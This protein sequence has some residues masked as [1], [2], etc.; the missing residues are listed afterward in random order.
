M[1]AQSP[2]SCGKA[3]AGMGSMRGSALCK[4]N[5]LQTVG[6]QRQDGISEGV[7]TLQAQSHTSCGKANAQ[8]E[9]VKGF[10]IIPR[11]HIPSDVGNHITISKAL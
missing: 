10:A 5:H 8:I 2:T 3:K 4:H 1:Q 11:E 6:R 7:C 9:S